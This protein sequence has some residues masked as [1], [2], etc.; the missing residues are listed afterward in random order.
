MKPNIYLIGET[1]VDGWNI[2]DS[3][4]YSIPDSE[5]GLFVSPAFVKDAE[6]RMCVKFDDID[7]WKT[8]FIVNA[9]GQI[10]FRAGGDDQ[11]RVNVKEG[12]QCYLNFSGGSGVYK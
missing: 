4:L 9:Q 12:Q 6:V 1:A 2:S 3:G 11:A 8:E 10:D 7:W 5:T